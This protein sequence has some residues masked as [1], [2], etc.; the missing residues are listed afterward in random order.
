MAACTAIVSSDPEIRA[1]LQAYLDRL[2]ARKPAWAAP[3]HLAAH[4]THSA[5]DWM[6]DVGCH[7]RVD[8]WSLSIV[9]TVHNEHRYWNPLRDGLRELGL[10]NDKSGGVPPMYR[11]AKTP[12][13]A[14]LQLLAGLL[15]SDGCLNK[16]PQFTYTFVQVGEDH[17]Q[18][19]C[20]MR[21][22]ALSCGI[23]TSDIS[24]RAS[25]RPGQVGY[26]DKQKFVLTLLK[27]TELLQ[28][29]LL[30]PRKRLNSLPKKCE[31]AVDL[32]P[33]LQIEDTEGWYR[34]IDV[35]GGLFQ[36]SN[37]LVVMSGRPA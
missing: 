16:P 20:D 34:S 5:G 7:A 17:R 18:M 13:C 14:R 24:T 1:W 21:E 23:S 35:S 9:S 31:H 8:V 29:Y 12:R 33:I 37:R 19:V 30:L 10:L 26:S 32:R 36:L 11:Q 22:I 25:T 15:D 27:G 3:V 2:N 28:E 4:K 6:P